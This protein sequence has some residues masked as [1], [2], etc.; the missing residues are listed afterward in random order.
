MTHKTSSFILWECSNS[1]GKLFWGKASQVQEGNLGQKCQALQRNQPCPGTTSING[2]R[3]HGAIPGFDRKLL[4]SCLPAVCWLQE[5]R[6][7]SPMF[8]HQRFGKYVVL[9]WYGKKK[10]KVR[11]CLWDKELFFLDYLEDGCLFWNIWRLFLIGA[12]TL[13]SNRRSVTLCTR[14]GSGKQENQ[15]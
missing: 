3:D 1:A 11:K 2:H 8:L 13:F 7:L 4:T 14:H 12:T 6:V 5:E 9:S 15:F 10:K